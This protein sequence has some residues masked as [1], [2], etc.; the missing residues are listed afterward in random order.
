VSLP[1]KEIWIW[2]SAKERPYADTGRRRSS[3]AKENNLDSDF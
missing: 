2:T 1:K 3:I